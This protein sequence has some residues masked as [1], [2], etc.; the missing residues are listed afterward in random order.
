MLGMSGNLGA[1]L[2]PELEGAH[3]PGSIQLWSL[4]PSG[5]GLD[6]GS[7]AKEGQGRGVCGG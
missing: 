5:E 3:S 2:G 4:N 6:L 7:Q 1:N